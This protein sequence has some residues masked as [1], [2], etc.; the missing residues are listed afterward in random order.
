M[1]IISVCLS[2]LKD[3][4][5]SL[6]KFQETERNPGKYRRRQSEICRLEKQISKTKDDMDELK[7]LKLINSTAPISSINFFGE[8]DD[9]H[10]KFYYDR[11]SYI[12][13]QYA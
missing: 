5:K 7:R 8:D 6:K 3:D 9:T 11:R 13:G 2:K 12:R 4:L 10:Q 1:A